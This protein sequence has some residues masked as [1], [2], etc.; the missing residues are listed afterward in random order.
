MIKDRNHFNHLKSTN[1]LGKIQTGK[2]DAA[3]DIE[4]TGKAA[5]ATKDAFMSL[6][7]AVWVPDSTVNLISLGA[8]M[9]KGASLSFNS[10]ITPST[11][12]LKLNGKTLLSGVITNN[13]FI[14]D[15]K[16]NSMSCHY[17]SAALQEIH[18]LLGHA[19]IARMERFL[20]QS[21]PLL[22]KEGFKC[23]SCDRAKIMKKPFS[24]Q[25]TIALR[26]F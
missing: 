15:M 26:C 22:T 19:S 11:F 16:T 25:Q 4:G 23:L 20:N 8:L 21:L 2:K 5:I 6:S 13:L 12:R 18:R 10:S 17:S 7:D 24:H 14:I 3:I 9:N 1:G